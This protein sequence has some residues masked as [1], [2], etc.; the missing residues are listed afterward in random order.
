[1]SSGD[2]EAYG[3]G[4]VFQRLDD[5]MQVSGHYE[6]FGIFFAIGFC[7]MFVSLFFIPSIPIDPGKFSALSAVGSLCM[8]FSLVF[9]KGFKSCIGGL[10]EG[11]RKLYA[12]AYIASLAI[13]FLAS[14]VLKNYF[15]S[16]LGAIAQ[17]CPLSRY[18][19]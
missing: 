9:I 8:M 1:M 3:S 4:G 10:V 17:V 12:L 13:T 14:M 2:P 11:E 6:Y 5:S 7:L 15:V 16:L 19:M 18:I